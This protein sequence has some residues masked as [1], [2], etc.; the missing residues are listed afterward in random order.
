MFN[1]SKSKY[2]LH[3]SSICLDPNLY[4]RR[5]QS[6]LCWS[7][8]CLGRALRQLRDVS[9]PNNVC[10]LCD[11]C[12]KGCTCL[13]RVMF[14]SYS[15]LGWIGL[16][17]FCGSGVEDVCIPD[18]VRVLCDRCFKECSSLRRVMFGSSSSSLERIGVSCFT[19]SGV[20]E[21]EVRIPNRGR[22]LCNRC[23]S[24]CLRHLKGLI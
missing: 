16:C 5:P 24:W 6:Q 2:M 18:S 9:I 7:S 22:M 23:L 13:R 3:E 11:D 14:G 17:C 1:R 4:R 12:F 19:S 10:K 21:E 8:T 15:S 20:E